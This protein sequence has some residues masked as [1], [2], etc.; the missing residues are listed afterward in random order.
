[1]NQQHHFCVILAGGKGRRLW[2]CSREKQPKQFLDFFGTGRT[3]LQQTFDRMAKI[4][5]AEQILVCTN[6]E[7]RHYVEEQLPQLPPDN[8]L[9]EPIHRNTA[10][11][12][13]WAC[14]RVLRTAGDGNLVVVPSDQAIFDE[15]KFK[16]NI[17]KGLDFVDQGNRLLAMGIAPTR[18]ETGYGYIQMGDSSDEEGLFKVKSFTEKPEEEFA[19]L[20]MNSGEFLWNTGIFLS[21]VRFLLQSLRRSLPSVLLPLEKSNQ[22]LTLEK[23]LSF[24]KE[25]FSRYPNLPIDYAVLEKADSGYV[26]KCD[27]GWA[28]M[29]TWL[30]IYEARSD[31]NGNNVVLDSKVIMDDCRDNIVKIPQ[32]KIA[33]LNGLDGYVVAEKDIVL[34][35]CKKNDSPS[36]IRRYINDSRIEDFDADFR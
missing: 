1:M 24:V 33:I 10:P 17:L 9:A 8:I 4:I 14:F 20:F 29:G 22:S 30:S 25:N 28:D 23:E 6:Q 15:E 21:R 2:P 18:P 5:P 11:S 26:M 16:A 27:F 31:G 35:I 13:A 34:L 32:G 7:Y 19:T 12:V 36:L 3:L